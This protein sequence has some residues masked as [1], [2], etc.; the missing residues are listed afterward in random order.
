MKV[1]LSL[2]SVLIVF[3]LFQLVSSSKPNDLL[4]NSENREVQ[5]VD[6][7]SK[8]M[9][10]DEKIGQ[11]FMV[12]AY[13]NKSLV[14]NNSVTEAVTKYHAGGVIFFQGGPQKLVEYN[15]YWRSLSK[16]PLFVAVDG[17]WGL[18]MRLKDSTI[19][20][21]KQ[22][23]LG[24]IQNDSLIYA[25]GKQIA[26]HCKRVGININFAPDVDVNSNPANPVINY[27]SFG[28]DP[29]NVA[30][31]GIAYMRGLQENGVLPTGKH[32]PGHG[33]TDKDSHKTLPMVTH[34]LQKMDSID[35][36]PFKKLIENNVAGVMVGHLFV[37]AYD[38]TS[39]KPSS[40]SQK[41]VTDL[42]RN[43]LNFQGLIF[44]DALNMKGAAS[45]DSAGKLEMK[46]FL[47]GNDVLLMSD[48][49]PKAIA[50]IKDT[51]TK[52]PELLK[53]LDQKC[54]R[55]LTY[56][57]RFCRTKQ[58]FAK[59]SVYYDLN[60]ASSE[61]LNRKLHE[62]SMT[63]VKNSH[64]LIPFQRLDTGSIASFQFNSSAL[65]ELDQTLGN[66][67]AISHFNFKAASDF[68]NLEL[69]DQQLATFKTIIITVNQTSNTSDNNYGFT[70]EIINF[71]ARYKNQKQIVLNLLC[72]PYSLGKLSDTS[73]IQAIIIGYQTNDYSLRASADALFGGNGM[74]GKLPVSASKFF[75]V[76][77][78][79]PTKKCRLCFTKP[80][81]WS[82]NTQFAKKIDSII[83]K[84]ITDTV[85]P[86]CQV[87]V[88]RNSNIIFQKSYGFQTYDKQIPI[89]NNSIYDIA[90]VTKIAATTLAIMKLYDEKKICLDSA[91]SFYLPELKHSN[92]EKLTIRQ[93]MTHQAGLKAWIPYYKE[94][95]NHG[96][97]D[98]AVFKTS[99]DNT[100]SIPVAD[101]LFMNKNYVDSLYKR[102]INSELRNNK[103]YMYSD[104][105]FYLL[106]ILIERQTKSTLDEYIT[107]SFYLPM[108]LNHTSYLPLKNFDVNTIVPSEN[109]TVF[110]HQILRGYVNDQGA[111]MLGGVSGHAGVFSTAGDLAKLMQLLLNHGNY[112]GITY[113]NPKTIDY[114]TS[115]QFAGN[116]RGIGF[117]KPQPD[118]SKEGPTCIYAT[119]NSYGHQGFTGTYVWVDP[120]Y[121]LI[122]VFISNRTYPYSVNNKLLTT[123]IRT[124][125]QKL[126]Y[127]SILK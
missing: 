13:S 6:S 49:L 61:L 101:N 8:T 71:I 57:Y 33:D 75:P 118:K 120:D 11:L 121:Q 21:P 111:A 48:N 114:F 76:N 69:I 29:V 89:D 52:N 27:R 85:F 41:I 55:I 104:L 68:K 42:L 5:W 106:K 59:K 43:Q 18:G 103:E 15:N 107:Q 82:L 28:E 90:S 32:F 100:F 127:E 72:N 91:L 63:L 99:K 65:N 54:K 108:G 25:M 20:F 12:A 93:I 64:N 73:G 56:K 47:A 81:E 117:D 126:L 37:P 35:L 113:F 78:G 14:D 9:T 110:R 62:A 7:V 125:I 94:F 67:G 34:T 70:D 123:G 36:Y 58:S 84:G 60:D 83:L 22:M 4:Y 46:A 1:F 26:A 53:V 96:K 39:N 31:K 102:I 119:P 40:I 45:A 23:T 50:R 122:Y 24:A 74:N 88:A 77:T 97:L 44:T 19:S 16:I 105:G 116:R 98:A 79:M 115:Y 51:I 95:L 3:S 2:A 80:Y 87:V 124:Q 38:T 109:D 92:K 66:Y 86:G 30:N 112:G 17:E 10:I